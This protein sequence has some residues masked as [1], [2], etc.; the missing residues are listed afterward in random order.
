MDPLKFLQSDTGGPGSAPAGKQGNNRN[1]N[2]EE[3]RSFYPGGRADSLQLR[4]GQLLP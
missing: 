1:S 3:L 2:M 4:G